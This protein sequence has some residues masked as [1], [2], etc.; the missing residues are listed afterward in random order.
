[1]DLAAVAKLTVGLGDGTGSDQDEEDLDT[2][3]I[4]HI[5]LSPPADSE[6]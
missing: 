4:D 3:Y 2:I 1:V 6:G 5:R